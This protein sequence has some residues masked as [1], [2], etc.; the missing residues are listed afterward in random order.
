MKIRS[1]AAVLGASILLAASAADAQ[2]A[3]QAPAPQATPAAAPTAAPAAPV[4]VTAEQRTAIKE[5]LDVTKTRDNLVR[6]FQAMSQNLA[7]QMAQAMNAKIEEA[8]ITPEQKLKVRESMNQPFANAMK[9]AAGIVNDP[10]NVDQ[11]MDKMYAIYAKNFTTDEIRQIIAF[12]KTPTGAKTLTAMPQVVNETML[13]GIATFQPRLNALV[14]KTVKAQVDA[15]AKEG[16]P[17]K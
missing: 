11:A 13:G 5:L 17:K 4:A 9:E 10:K 1:H 15:V 16:A 6:T 14:D 12:Y 7:A 8:S 2:Q 3:K